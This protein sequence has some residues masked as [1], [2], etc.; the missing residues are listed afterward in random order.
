MAQET[1]EV[2]ILTVL[3]TVLLSIEGGNQLFQ[4]QAIRYRGVVWLAPKWKIAPDEK[5]VVPEWII[6]IAQFPHQD[7]ERPTPFGQFGV[8][9]PLPKALIEGPISQ[10]IEK[11]YSVVLNPPIRAERPRLQ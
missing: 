11:R 4:S 7:L 10:E 5:Y 8:N 2:T 6:P 3:L 1:E 9:V